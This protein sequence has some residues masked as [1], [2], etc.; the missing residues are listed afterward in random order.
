MKTEKY[1]KKKRFF[2][3]FFY[4][5]SNILAAMYPRSM[6]M[7]RNFRLGPCLRLA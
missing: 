5:I 3:D 7:I 1:M 2:L 4:K 6:N